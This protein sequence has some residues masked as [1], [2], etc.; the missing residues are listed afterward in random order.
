MNV[1]NNVTL[2]ERYLHYAEQLVESGQFPS[3][4]KV[5][6][7]GIDTLRQSE[8]TTEARDPLAGMADE[9]R[10]RMELPRDQWIA[11]DK[12]NLFD[13]VRARLEEKHKGN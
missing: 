1:K 7:A 11:M 13:R 4:E 10:R 6:E 12:D 8:E 9:I 2:S 5:L 3:V